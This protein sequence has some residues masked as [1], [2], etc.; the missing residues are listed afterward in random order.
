M[1]TLITGTSGNRLMSISTGGGDGGDRGFSFMYSGASTSA[2][3]SGTVIGMIF[4]LTLPLSEGHEKRLETD[5]GV[6][7]ASLHW[8]ERNLARGIG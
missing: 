1:Y 7:R 8:E 4:S 6:W 2:G 5:S 3:I